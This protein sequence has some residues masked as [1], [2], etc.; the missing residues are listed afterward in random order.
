MKLC[1]AILTLAL[2]ATASPA[3]AAPAKSAKPPLSA[4]KAEN[5]AKAMADWMSRIMAAQDRAI[6]VLRPIDE[7][8]FQLETVSAAKDQA[9]INAAHDNLNIVLAKAKADLTLA[10]TEV[11]TLP[12]LAKNSAMAQLPAGHEPRLRKLALESIG[13]FSK[14]VDRAETMALAAAS[15][16]QELVIEFQDLMLDARTEVLTG[17][18][19]RIAVMS[20]STKNE[21]VSEAKLQILAKTTEAML[22]IFKGQVNVIRRLPADFDYARLT[23]LAGEVEQLRLIGQRALKAEKAQ[24]ARERH[25]IFP[26]MIP[27][28]ERMYAIH[29]EWAD[30]VESLPALFQSLPDRVREADNDLTKLDQVFRIVAGVEAEYGRNIEKLVTNLQGA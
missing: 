2:L 7:A 8:W 29:D 15:G 10:K 11:E 12:S 26:A 28:N 25:L 22:I 13:Q 6:N 9:A 30:Y 16:E 1:A 18:L 3:L 21:D 5:D 17:Q 4:K 19:G 23:E 24:F 27:A 14:I 20:S